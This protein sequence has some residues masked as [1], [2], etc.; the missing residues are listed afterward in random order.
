[1]SERIVNDITLQYLTN[2]RVTR[3]TKN[4][5]PAKGTPTRKDVRFYKKRIMDMARKL[6]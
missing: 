4:E 3:A 6:M 2:V 5:S 1:M